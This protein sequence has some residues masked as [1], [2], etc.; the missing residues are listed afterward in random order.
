MLYGPPMLEIKKIEVAV[1][2]REMMF[3]FQDGRTEKVVLKVG[4]PYEYGD[5]LDWCCPYEL[6]T[7]SSRKLFGMF[8]VDALQALEL[9]IKTLKVE[10]EYWEKFKKGKFYFLGE[11]GAGI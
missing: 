9:T 10:V 1:A 8:G 4:M 11:E 6:S 3:H 5:G 2:L 7:E